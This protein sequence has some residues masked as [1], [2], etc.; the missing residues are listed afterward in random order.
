MIG[1][2]ALLIVTIA[3]PLHIG[4][5]S[6]DNWLQAANSETILVLAKRVLDQQDRKG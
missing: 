6:P 5:P 2:G 3:V 4:L 1:T